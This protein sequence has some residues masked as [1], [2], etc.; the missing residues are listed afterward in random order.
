GS[1]REFAVE[2]R[3]SAGRCSMTGLEV[4][5]RFAAAEDVHLPEGARRIHDGRREQYASVS[6]WRQSREDRHLDDSAWLKRQPVWEG[7]PQV[8][9]PADPVA[10]MGD[11]PVDLWGRFLPPELPSGLLPPLIEDFARTRGRLMGADPAGLAVAA[12]VTCAAA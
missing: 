12:L 8:S 3:R 7:S 6:G 4:Q 5:A 10:G 9:M 2:R 11:D 1:N